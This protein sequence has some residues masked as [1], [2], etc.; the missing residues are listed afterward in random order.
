MQGMQWLTK[1]DVVRC[2]WTCKGLQ[3]E[4]AGA[5]RDD[6]DD[7]EQPA[8]AAPAQPLSAGQLRAAADTWQGS[9]M[10]V[11]MHPDQ[12]RALLL[13]QVMAATPRHVLEGSCWA[14]ARILRACRS[15]HTRASMRRQPVHAWNLTD[16]M[17]PALAAAQLSLHALLQATE[18][19]VGYAQR[20]RKPFAVVPCCVYGEAFP[21]R[22]LPDGRLVRSYDDL[23]RYI[24]SKD[25][26]VQMRELPF[27]GRN[28]VLWIT[29]WTE[30]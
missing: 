14:V 19:I 4:D 12:A 29:R 20:A 7:E 2:R 15:C 28:K 24:L 25:P 8:R 17:A 5:G 26:A 22:R 10:L 21:R 11:G 9:S 23:L 16:D 6:S 13:L 18:A 30:A 3:H 27:E 1:S